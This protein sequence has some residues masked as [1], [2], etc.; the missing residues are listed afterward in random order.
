MNL[1]IGEHPLE[2]PPTAKGQGVIFPKPFY[3]IDLPP[4]FSHMSFLLIE[5]LSETQYGEFVT[6][7]Q[8]CKYETMVDLC[9]HISH[10][11]KLNQQEVKEIQQ[12][13]DQILDNWLIWR[14]LNQ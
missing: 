1:R 6:R 8:K 7:S 4:V 11:Y 5:T 9:G 3:S 13:Y 12:M 14:Q 2:A 10:R